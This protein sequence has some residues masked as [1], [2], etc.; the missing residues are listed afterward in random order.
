MSTVSIAHDEEVKE[1]LNVED[2]AV[3]RDSLHMDVEKAEEKLSVDRGVWGS[4]VEFVMTCIS[5]A[6]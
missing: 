5:Y 6:G 4:Q 2:T 3:K 1:S